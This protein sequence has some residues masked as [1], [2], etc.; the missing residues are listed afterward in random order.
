MSKSYSFATVVCIG[1]IFTLIFSAGAFAKGNAPPENPRQKI[2][3]DTISESPDP[4]SPTVGPLTISA[5]Y[6]ILPTDS[7]V[8]TANGKTDKT[9]YIRQMIEILDAA[10]AVI[11]MLEQDSPIDPTG[12][13]NA[14]EYV[15]TATSAIWDGKNSQGN[16]PSDGAYTYKVSG[17]YLRVQ[18]RGNDRLQGKEIALS[19]TLQ[20]NV[21]L[22]ATATVTQ[23]AITPAANEHGWHKV[24][25][26][27][28]LTAADNLSGVAK[29]L[30]K[31][32]EAASVE[33]THIDLSDEGVYSISYWSVDN[34]GNVEQAKQVTIRIDK[35]N[36]LISEK[37]RTPANKWGWNNG[38][39]AVTYKVSDALSGVDEQTGGY[40]PDTVETEGANQQV[41]GS[42]TD[43]A[44]NTASITVDGINIDLTNPTIVAAAAGTVGQNNWWVSQVAISYTVA[45]A[46]SGIDPEL[47]DHANDIL[48]EGADQTTQGNVYDKAGNQA[49][50][51][52]A[53]M[54]VD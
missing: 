14:S 18:K 44:G 26:A 54:D 8:G 28:D 2:V 12:I 38:P 36:P 47:G 48:G 7:L 51:Q 41:E 33:G 1:L 10:G 23:A 22:D 31:I 32:G 5:S 29:T 45:D 16:L 3:L 9:F 46:L 30:Y 40:E 21:S 49:S 6:R 24:D 52:V 53:D 27:V 4:F 34:V 37:S 17:T 25:V 39:V 19:A 42:V 13:K 43:L 50:T 15:Q 11:R 35:T 20:G